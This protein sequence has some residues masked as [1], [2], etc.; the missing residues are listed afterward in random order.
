MTEVVP[1]MI[2]Y[3]TIPSLHLFGLISIHTYGVLLMVGILM[4]NWLVRR[5]AKR[6]GIETG[7]IQN[8]VIWAV[9]GGFIGAHLLEILFYQP[10]LIERDG[11]IVILEIW[12]GLSSFGGFIGGLIASYVYFRRL[13]RP[14]LVHVALILEGLVIGWIFGRLGCTLAHDHIGRRTSFFLAFNYSSGPRHNLGFYEFL[15][16]L[17]VLFPITLLF[18]RDRIKSAI[19]VA[20]IS[21]IYGSV[22]FCLDFLRATDVPGADLRYWGLTAAQFGCIALL[23]VGVWMFFKA[24]GGIEWPL[25]RLSPQHFAGR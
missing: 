14:Y 16:A 13:N 24:Q 7:E 22:R 23:G 8:A 6:L 11:F 9:A 25:R 17:I 19:Y 1:T 3:F 4:G 10:E 18:H 15:L 21:L 2:P 20:A 12:K 5:R